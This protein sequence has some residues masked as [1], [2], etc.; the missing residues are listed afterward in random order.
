MK[1]TVL[2][3]LHRTP[4]LL[5]AKIR[6]ERGKS[7]TRL[8]N[9]LNRA[10]PV[11]VFAGVPE[12][13]QLSPAPAVPIVTLVWTDGSSSAPRPTALGETGCSFVVVDATTRSLLFLLLHRHRT[14]RHL[15]TCPLPL[16]ILRRSS[17][18]L[19]LAAPSP[20]PL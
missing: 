17:A 1:A 20:D 7:L 13:A 19:L 4:N 18:A 5:L 15:L 3:G 12:C 6:G 2:A 8:S 9:R 16:M 11:G 10:G 14:R